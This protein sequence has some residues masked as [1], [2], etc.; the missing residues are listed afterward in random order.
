MTAR[1]FLSST[2][3]DLAAHRQAVQAAMRKLGVADVS[4]EN[5][6]AREERPAD[7]CLR[8]V[9][10]ESDLFVGIYAH[11]YG[12][13]PEGHDASM[14]ELEY[15]AAGEAALPRF[16]YIV[17]D[18]HPWL[19]A[20][21]DRGDAAERLGAFKRG[22]LARHMCQP[23]GTADQ[24]AALVAADLGRHLALR[25]IQRVGPD[26]RLQDTGIDSLRGAPPE[27]P[28][29]WNARRKAVYDAHR[30]IFLT[31]LIQPSR[32]PGQ[33]FDVS[34][35]LVRHK[36]SDFADV[37]MAEF[38]LGRH[39]ANKVFPAFERDGVIGIS[40]AAFGTFLCICRVTFNDGQHVDLERYIDFESHRAGGAARP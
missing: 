29:A 31:H 16:I 10:E 17:D 28:D 4:M 18:S 23:F 15:R 27:T 33:A 6:G 9:R 21:I 40:T 24:L 11:R 35:Y 1:V 8:L 39:W 32:R 12:F 3:A 38:F 25:N 19:P 22:L 13:V 20:H 7:E 36:R 26:T 14:S 37:R 30:G 2:F 5:F 34:I